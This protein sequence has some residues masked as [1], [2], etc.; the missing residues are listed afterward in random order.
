LLGSLIILVLATGGVA[1][2]A[3]AVLSQPDACSTL[4]SSLWRQ[5]F[6]DWMG[7]KMLPD[8]QLALPLER[9]FALS[10]AIVVLLWLA[11][12]A[13]LWRFGRRSWRSSARHWAY[14]G[15]LWGI[16]CGE[17]WIVWILLSLMG[18]PTAASLLDSQTN[19]F[20][21]LVLAGATATLTALVISSRRRADAKAVETPSPAGDVSISRRPVIAV[22]AVIAV[23]LIYTAVYF[24]LNAKLYENLLVPHG[25]SAMYEEHL[26]NLEHGKGFRS[27]LDAGLFLGEH[28][29][30]IHVLLVPLHLLWP[31][32]LLLELC[33]SA[34]LALAAWPVFL[35]ARRHTGSPHVGVLMAIAY[36]CYVPM[37]YI[38][39]SI[40]LKTFRP[41][42]LGIGPLLMAID[43]L[44]RGRYRQMSLW[45]LLA[46]S[47]QEDFAIPIGCL[48]AWLAVTNS[49]ATWRKR[50]E[51][52]P[53]SNPE[54]VNRTG[55]YVG[56]GVLA[57]SVVY[58]LI[59]VKWAIP[60]F[61]GSETVHYARYFPQFGQTPTEIVWNMLT[62]PGLLF[63]ELFTAGM[64]VYT[65]HLLVPL[66]FASLLSPTRLL[67]GVPLWVLLC[68][69]ELAHDPYL[70]VHHFHAPL[71]PIL[72]WSAIAG[73]AN[74]GKLWNR[75]SSYYA[76]SA[77]RDPS[78]TKKAALVYATFV[79]MCSV[80]TGLFEGVGPQSLQFWDP[81]RTFY[82]RNLYIITDRAR[83]FDKI[84]D[85]IP[86]TARVASTDFVHPRF[87]HHE[88]SYDYSKYERAV[89]DNTTNVPDD[90]D[91]IV[92]DT[93]HRYS[94]IHAPDQV[95]ELQEEP[96]QWELLPDETD[97][98]FIV[99]K[100]REAP[101]NEP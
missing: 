95:R 87:T 25:D 96:E 41:T 34:A 63:S 43:T 53:Q 85:D 49:I 27:Y 92:I 88:R 29:Q 47:A 1:M 38:D 61:H 42:A 59:A 84:A 39:I 19:L 97:G 15:G 65:L 77:H 24:T 86:Q 69:N 48:G 57:V 58:L 32:H 20:V 14:F 70:P 71:I 50:N 30:V 26:W 51:P 90:T 78:S 9:V 91:Y 80:F 75:R 72:I 12:S 35:I 11:G 52:S 100:R 83:S 16:T 3:D 74:A 10:A 13:I 31:S 73:V 22:I 55:L 67:V 54:P 28:I 44:E 81:G 60:W 33:Q 79:M 2:F 98:Y 37:Q 45:M 6:A 21:A 101:P 66:G 18:W 56:L 46:L 68:L 89:A 62:K 36:L 64:I 8:D 99:L 17:W 76:N 82:W 4:V 23:M 5:Q 93:G 94:W 7:A 40:D